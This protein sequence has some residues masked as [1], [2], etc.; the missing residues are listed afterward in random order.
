[1]NTCERYEM[2]VHLG[3]Q[4]MNPPDSTRLQTHAIKQKCNGGFIPGSQ[5]PVGVLRLASGR[6]DVADGPHVGPHPRNRDTVCQQ[7]PVQLRQIRGAG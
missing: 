2:I 7:W 4:V 5:P 6:A 3:R 1:M